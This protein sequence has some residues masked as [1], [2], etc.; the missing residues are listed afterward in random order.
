MYFRI[1]SKKALSKLFSEI[2]SEAAECLCFT[3]L[4]A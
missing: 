3:R 2:V 1:D 4:G